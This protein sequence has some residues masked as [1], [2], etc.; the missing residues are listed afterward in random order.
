M[1]LPPQGRQRSHGF[2]RPLLII[3]TDEAADCHVKL[4]NVFILDRTVKLKDLGPATFD[5]LAFR[6]RFPSH[7]NLGS[8][9]SHSHSDK[10]GTIVSSR[11]IKGARVVGFYPLRP[12]RIPSREFTGSSTGYKYK[13]SGSYCWGHVVSRRNTVQRCCWAPSLVCGNRDMQ[14]V[15]A[16]SEEWSR[17]C[18]ARQLLSRCVHFMGSYLGHLVSTVASSW[19]TP[20]GTPNKLDV[21]NKCEE[22]THTQHTLDK[23][24]LRAP[25][26]LKKF[27]YVSD[28]WSTH[29]FSADWASIGYGCLSYLSSAKQGKCFSPGLVRRGI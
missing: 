3:H 18:H 20:A 22:N 2:S 29:P 7:S 10:R 23:K 27:R 9:S 26:I 17:S 21:Q 19:V 28:V 14:E 6:R 4:E 5:A 16:I 24:S 12:T 1:L 15:P 8:F 25:K 11:S 13:S